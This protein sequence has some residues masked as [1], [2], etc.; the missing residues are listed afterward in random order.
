MGEKMRWGGRES[1]L[2]DFVAEMADEGQQGRWT[3]ERVLAALDDPRFDEGLGGWKGG[4]PAG[5]IE[6]WGRLSL[7]FRLAVF[8]TAMARAT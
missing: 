1:E 4:V 7:D 6:N 3:A 5:F 2:I 8:A